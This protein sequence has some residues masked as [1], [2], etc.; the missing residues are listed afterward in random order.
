MVYDLQKLNH[1]E[2][3]ELEVFIENFGKLNKNLSNKSEY[4]GDAAAFVSN[5]R[6]ESNREK[7]IKEFKKYLTVD[8]YGNGP[9]SDPGLVCPRSDDDK[10]LKMLESSYKVNNSDLNPNSGM[11]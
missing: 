10:C 1:E 4:K 5:C 6:S 3:E 11:G 8:V 2:D 9:C 7:V